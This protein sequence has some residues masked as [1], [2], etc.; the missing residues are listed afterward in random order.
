[1]PLEIDIA[2]NMATVANPVAAVTYLSSYVHIEYLY[3]ITIAQ[4][5]ATTLV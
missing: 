5:D 2:S 1:M 3:Q 4:L